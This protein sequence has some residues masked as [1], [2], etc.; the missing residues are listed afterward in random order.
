[1]LSKNKIFVENDASGVSL[2]LS[3][4]K[5]DMIPESDQLVQKYSEEFG[6]ET[7]EM[8]ADLFVGVST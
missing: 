5:D 6:H 7:G 4:I 8:D 1:M 3:T 2:E